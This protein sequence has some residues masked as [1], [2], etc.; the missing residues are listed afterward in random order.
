MDYAFKAE[1]VSDVILTEEV[2]VI[3]AGGRVFEMHV[4]LLGSYVRSAWMSFTT[5]I[6]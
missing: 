1:Y 5:A 2:A 6:L 4:A 3:Y